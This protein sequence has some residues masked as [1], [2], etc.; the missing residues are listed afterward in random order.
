MN[1]KPASEPGREVSS[2]SW[3]APPSR[4]LA[5]Q[6]LPRRRPT[7]DAAAFAFAFATAI[8]TAA[9][10]MGVRCMAAVA[11]AA[12]ATAAAATAYNDGGTL[13]PKLQLL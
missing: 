12:V 11:V 9:V 4:S 10:T 5:L 3:S 1:W 8:A 2:R 6:L 7:F 13:L